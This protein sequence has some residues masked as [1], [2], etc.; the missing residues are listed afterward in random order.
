MAPQTAP[1]DAGQA[2]SYPGERAVYGATLTVQPT[3]PGLASKA[4]ILDMGEAV[5]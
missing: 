3:N 4:T 2:I 1:N 5:Q